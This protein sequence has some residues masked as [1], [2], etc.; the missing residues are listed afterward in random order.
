MSISPVSS[1]V[2]KGEVQMLRRM[3]LMFLLVL[4][5]TVTAY[6]GVQWNQKTDNWA[7]NPNPVPGDWGFNRPG[8]NQGLY[9]HGVSVPPGD[10][11]TNLVVYDNDIS[12]DVMDDDWGFLMASLGKMKLAA[13]ICTP[14]E[15]GPSYNSSFWQEFINDYNRAA[16]SNLCMDNIPYPTKGNGFPEYGGVQ[17]TSPGAQLYVQLAAQA[18]PEKPMVVNIG[19][20]AS[21][22]AKAY[23]LDNSI[24]EKIVVYYTDIIA[25]NGGETWGSETVARN[26]RVIN[27]GRRAY[28]WIWWT[29]KNCQNEWQVLP[30]PDA[31]CPGTNKAL[32]GEWN[33]IDN[34]T[35]M[36]NWFL[37]QMYDPGVGCWYV[38]TSCGGCQGHDF[39]SASDGYYDGTYIAAFV[40]NMIT[41]AEVADMRGGR[42]MMVTQ[43]NE[44]A[45]KQ[46]TLPILAN[47]AA[48]NGCTPVNIESI[49]SVSTSQIDLT[50][51]YQN[52]SPAQFEIERKTGSGSFSLIATVPSTQLSY[53][54]TGL[55]ANTAYTYRVRALLNGGGTSAYSGEETATTWDNPPAAP[56][57]LVTTAN[58]SAL[59]ISLTWSDNSD[60]EEGFI[61]ER[62]SDGDFSEVVTV[63]SNIESYDDNNALGGETYY[64][65]RVR[66]VN[67]GGNQFSAWSNEDCATTPCIQDPQMLDDTAIPPLVYSTGWNAQTGWA[68]RYN[69]TIHESDTAGAYVEVTLMDVGELKIYGDKRDYAGTAE[70][71]IDGVSQGNIS[72]NGS[73]ADFVLIATLTNDLG[74][75]EH[76]IRITVNG[77]GWCYI[78]AI[79][80]TPLC[81]NE[82]EN[83]PADPGNLTAIGVGS[84]QIELS[85]LD[86]SGDNMDEEAVF[87]VERR[88]ADGGDFAEVAT[89][90][91]IPGTG[92]TVKHVDSGLLHATGYYYRVRASN[93]VAGED[94]YS[95]YTSPDAYAVTD[96]PNPPA[97]PTGLTATADDG[98]V[99]L[100][101]A[102]NVEVDPAVLY[103][104]IHRSTAEGGPY[105]P[106]AVAF[107]ASHIT[108]YSVVNDTT[109]YYKV[110]AVDTWPHVSLE[111]DMVQSTPSIP[112]EPAAPTGLQID[113]VGASQ[114][115][116]SWT[117]NSDNET[118][119]EV[120]KMVA[121]SGTYFLLAT[122]GVNVTSYTDTVLESGTEYCYRV[123]A[124]NDVG[125][126]GYS[127]EV[128]D[129]TTSCVPELM[130]IDDA[131]ATI[132]YTGN[133][134]AQSGWS[135]RY[136]G[137]LHETD[138]SGA[139][140]EYTFTGTTIELI[141]ELQ[142]WGGSAEV[143]LDGVSQGT[144]SFT[145]S[146]QY[147]VSVFSATELDDVTHTI[148]L[149]VAG[150]GWVY[151]DAVTFT[152]C[153]AP[154]SPPAAPTNLSASASNTTIN[155]AWTDNA[156][157]EL[158]YKVERKTDGTF[159][160]VAV[161]GPNAQSYADFG[162]AA[163][164]TYTY[165]VRAY[166]A[167]GNSAYS[168]EDAAT[169]G[170]AV[171]GLFPNVALLES[172]YAS[173][174]VVENQEVDSG[175]NM[176]ANGWIG[177][178]GVD[179]GDG[180][181]GDLT[182]FNY[183]QLTGDF[184]IDAQVQ[185]FNHSPHVLPDYNHQS[186]LIMARESLDPRSRFFAGGVTG[187]QGFD[188][189]HYKFFWRN[190]TGGD[191]TNGG[192]DI[193]NGFADGSTQALYDQGK[194][195]VRF[196]RVGDAFSVW[197]SQTGE[198]GSWVYETGRDSERWLA[199]DTV[200]VGLS[201]HSLS[202]AALAD[203][204]IEVQ[205]RNITISQP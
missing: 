202:T 100:D 117:D 124:I 52:I 97:A 167:G 161:I 53:N 199:P 67:S 60:N 35:P 190:V 183:V 139:A 22:L 59:Q 168:N 27:W 62:K 194:V 150:G 180:T 44:P 95:G 68:G 61:I 18:S 135:G 65:Y 56:S 127:N 24:A 43:I 189:M 75:G 7:S 21:T 113:L 170:D 107:G 192:A 184:T 204:A 101:W 82:A 119:F 159:T 188:P 116:I 6:G 39:G 20:Q 198:S 200:Y 87:H 12:R 102:D 13:Y 187:Y 73:S 76:T 154:P 98:K 2:K 138:S 78:D 1:C 19:G 146:T 57:N 151:L 3:V 86:N 58:P 164:T 141:G 54:N 126:S 114:M 33:M 25:F 23:Y 136:E 79:E 160:E 128:C 111:S 186:A 37:R 203:H 72:Y 69:Q 153:V 148:R 94:Q 96:D 11:V 40:Q 47:Q 71:T 8:Y 80:Y 165:R 104:V 5:A 30:R 166:N 10:P 193:D 156:S 178:H 125:P 143:I 93:S 163:Q 51:S 92:N 110:T 122:V 205:W 149:V 15:G 36:M 130:T 16:D 142:S 162:L 169:T 171:T 179:M 133:W 196:Q 77:D 140:A 173:L 144:V 106:V 26:F 131:D 137:T 91:G 120:E 50:W 109:Y 31:C 201:C 177:G 152:G 134:N 88:A 70:V 158:G 84:S 118:G 63:G 74:C 46:G 105:H 112:T 41:N 195:W 34:G 45:V 29:D 14:L 4:A 38:P 157:N 147:Q 115:T 132:V 108:D 129:T 176:T 85:W 17:G 48:F 55:S 181:K 123:R 175:Y 32:W 81:C 89:V 197:S 64:C 185:L 66:A 191:V 99:E 155:L 182:V 174:L 172:P 103:Y 9:V 42:V 90:S 145:G 49:E 28:Q 121:A 83:P